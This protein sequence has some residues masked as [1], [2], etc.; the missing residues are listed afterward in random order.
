MV[1]TDPETM[2]LFEVVKSL[3]KIGINENDETVSA[4]SWVVARFD[5][6]KPDNRLAMAALDVFESLAKDQGSIDQSAIRTIN[7]IM[8]GPYIKIVK[9][10]AHEV[11]ENLR[12]MD[13]DDNK[14]EEKNNRSNNS[15]NKNNNNNAKAK[16]KT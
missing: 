4:I 2:V 7:K 9:D 5:N 10:R 15:N 6:L 12:N 1:L 3:G 13:N 8:Q 14:K 11:L 16:G